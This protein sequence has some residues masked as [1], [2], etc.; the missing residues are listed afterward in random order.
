MDV[1]RASNFQGPQQAPVA[2]AAPAQAQMQA[3]GAE[4]AE[5]QQTQAQ[6][7]SLQ[8]ATASVQAAEMRRLDREASNKDENVLD[9]A[10]ESINR[11]LESGNR[12]FSIRMHE[13][14]GRKMISIYNSDNEVIREIPPEKVLD[15]HA[16]MLQ[17]AGLLVDKR[18]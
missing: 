18:G 13:T 5:T 14:T 12:H 1:A 17:L 2:T 15:A 3:Q 10:V 11:I 4:F 9:R 6:P 16:S 8:A 7:A